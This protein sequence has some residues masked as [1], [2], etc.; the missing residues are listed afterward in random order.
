[1]D[2][3]LITILDGI[4]FGMI[5]F[6]IAAGLSLVMGVMGILNLA[7]GALFM[8]GAYI[9][10]TVT[11]DGGGSFWLGL[12]AAGAG[13]ALL[14]VVLERGLLRRMHDQLD[15]QVL[16]TLGVLFILTNLSIWIWTA[17]AKP[18]YIPDVFDGA[19]D[20][21][22]TGYPKSRIAVIVIATLIAIALWFIQERTRLGTM[23]RAGMDDRETA[24]SLG[25]NVGLV[26]AAVFAIG[27]FVVG[28]SGVLGQQLVGVQ[29]E[30]GLSM[31]LL[32]LI[33]LIVGGVGTIQGALVGALAVGLIRSVGLTLFPSFELLLVYGA[34]IVVLVVRPQGL[35]GRPAAV[36]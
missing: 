24:A 8:L 25:V 5:L 34:V 16:A 15:N 33:V 14:G 26:S 2:S 4:S 22:G 11:V 17:E 30:H 31:L 6:L 36:Q 1:M 29:P 7:H 20:I 18:P 23:V 10:W 13:V 21:A 3:T 9:G 35:L 28:I 12:L 19:V 27:A 32:A